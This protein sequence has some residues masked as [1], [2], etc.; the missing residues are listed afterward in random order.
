[1][2]YYFAM[3]KILLVPAI[4]LLGFPMLVSCGSPGTDAIG[5]ATPEVK[6]RLNVLL[7]IHSYDPEAVKKKCNRGTGNFAD[8]GSGPEISDMSDGTP[9]TILDSD[10][11]VLQSFNV[12]GSAWGKQGT[13]AWIPTYS[14]DGPGDSDSCIYDVEF[15]EGGDRTNSERDLKI[16]FSEPF[17]SNEFVVKI[18]K[19]EPFTVTSDQFKLQPRLEGYEEYPDWWELNVFLSPT[20]D[21][22]GVE[23]SP[24]IWRMIG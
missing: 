10:G 9:V 2:K 7:Y 19:R 8:L 3:R 14:S 21:N 15:G 11:N 6:N 16:P 18:G 5:E 12:I 24:T 4:L 1:M 22:G 23:I 20:D 13:N 17:S